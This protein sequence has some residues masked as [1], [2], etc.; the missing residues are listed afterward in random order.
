MEAKIEIYGARNVTHAV[1][2]D[3]FSLILKLYW[4]SYSIPSGKHLLEVHVD[5]NVLN[6]DQLNFVFLKKCQE[7]SDCLVYEIL[8]IK[9]LEP[10]LNTQTDPINA[11]FFV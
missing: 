11:K 3:F 1:W 5:K 4:A 8:F 2:N 6:E 10:S 7:K 9:E